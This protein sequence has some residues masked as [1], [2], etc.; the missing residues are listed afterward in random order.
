MY[1]WDQDNPPLSA[2][3]SNPGRCS[4]GSGGW[5]IE[6]TLSDGVD[7]S[8]IYDRAM[9]IL[10]SEDHYGDDIEAIGPVAGSENI[11]FI[12]WISQELNH[13]ESEQGSV[14]F[15]ANGAAFWMS[16]IPSWPDGVAL[17]TGTPTGWTQVKDL[18][19]DLGVY[20]FLRHR[21]TITRIMDVTLSGDTRLSPEVSSSAQNV[22]SQLQE[23]TWNQIYARPGVNALNQLSIQ[24]HPCLIPTGDRAYPTVMAITKADYRNGIDFD[25]AI[26]NE[27]GILDMSGLKVTGPTA[28]GAFFALAPGHSL[29]NTGEWDIQPN[30][31]LSS[32]AQV[33]TLA[34]LYRSWRNNPFKAI[35]LTFRAPIALID[36]FPNQKCTINIAAADTVRGIAYNGGLIPTSVALVHDPKTGYLHTEV[37]FEAE[38]VESQSI[39]GDTPGSGD[40][41]Q[42]PSPSFPPLTL[43]PIIIPGL[44]EP[45]ATGP[46]TVLLHDQGV[47]LIVARN[48]DTTPA[49]S[50]VNGGL[51]DGFAPAINWMFKCQNG[52]IY[53][54]HVDSAPG[55][56]PGFIARSP[57]VGS[58][59]EILFNSDEDEETLWG[60]GGNLNVSESIAIIKGPSG[61]PHH[62]YVGA[63]GSF[64]E[65]AVVPSVS[66]AVDN[67]TYGFGKWLYTVF[68]TYMKFNPDGSSAGSGTYAGLDREHIRAGSTGIT[69]HNRSSKLFRGEDNMATLIEVEDP[70][71]PI[72]KSADCDPTGTYLMSPQSGKLKSPDGG[73][74]WTG[75]P[76]LPP[77]SWCF[78]YAGTGDRP[79]A[80]RFIAAGAV[81][82]YTPD[83]GTT[84]VNKENASLTG[85]VPIPSIN[86]VL[87]LEP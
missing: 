52:A 43:P 58:N 32:Q 18:T 51:P 72:G 61:G 36:C 17:T 68:N 9:V 15:I 13:I 44:P 27:I 3:I 23:M 49:Y 56:A 50:L 75:I 22:W 86:R 71:N 8:E 79:T 29:P 40:V 53:V 39:Q 85:I 67:L 11:K 80:P 19:V 82:R 62:I 20:H 83:F 87:V 57:S 26:I 63:G 14:T 30:L 60:I 24:I 64:A 65:G 21:T 84:W 55:G 66:I 28:A 16:K 77:G 73:Y 35:P 70:F 54:A 10:F 46:K 4:V 37:T 33:I 47:G 1:V 69:F 38:T 2:I 42:P 34:G 31:L 59:F 41:S 5:E 7:L 81:V 74:T 76:S 25:R 78:G 12:G 45:T 6:I 48:F